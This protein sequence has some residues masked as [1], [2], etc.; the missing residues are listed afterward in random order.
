[1]ARSNPN[2]WVNAGFV[3]TMGALHD[4][5]LSLVKACKQASGL[6]VASIF[7]NP[8]QFNDPADFEKYP[9]T[10]DRDVQLLEEAGCDILFL[11]DTRE[12]YPDGWQQGGYFDLG[13]L[14]KV[15]E[16]FYRP[17]HFQ[18]VCQVVDRLLNI[19]QP[20]YLFMGQK[21]FQQCMVI[22]RLIYIKKLD[23]QLITCPTLREQDG[24][25]MSSRNLRLSGEE[26]QNATAI[27]KAMLQLKTGLGKIPV[28]ELES[29]ASAF[30]VQNGFRSIDYVSICQP[31][32]LE[33]L[34]DWTPGTPAVVLVAAFMGDI[35]LI[36]NLLLND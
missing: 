7:V 29:K 32:T 2:L 31:A 14:E 24:L 21:D 19:I 20:K 1:M 25:A 27:Y 23:I 10:L 36:D 15:L 4:G 13:N 22:Q 5:H 35:R 18:G 33:P 30:L 6:V 17:G 16:G 34:E 12:I 9:V 11:P 3:P 28:R 8:S 26:R